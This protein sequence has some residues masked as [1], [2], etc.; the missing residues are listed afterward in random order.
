MAVTITSSDYNGDFL[1]FLY[2]VLTIGNEIVEKGAARMLTGIA[3]KRALPKLSQTANPMGAYTTGVPGAETVTTT[4]SERSLEPNKMTLYE[5]FVPEDT[6]DLWDKWQPQG[7]FTNL[8]QNPEFMADVVSMYANGS[9]TQFARLFWQGDKALTTADPLGHIDGIVTRCKADGDVIAVTPAGAIT[10]ANV[11]DRIEEVWAAIPTKFFRESRYLIMMN[12]TDYKLLQQFNNDAKKGTVGVLSEN[13]QSLFLEKRIVEFDGLPKDHIVAALVDPNSDE[14]NFFTGA[15][16]SLEG[17]NP[18]INKIAN[19]GKTWFTRID[20][21]LDV[22][23]REAS[24]I[25]FYEPV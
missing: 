14:S 10:K 5:T 11:V 2:L 9:G 8:R 4:Y 13:I 16:V 25:V 23:Y 6:F 3:K 15:W 22:N 24:E 1:A 12:T 18:D 19:G 7:D 21:M 20:W 17:E